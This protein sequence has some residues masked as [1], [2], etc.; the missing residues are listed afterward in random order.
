MVEIGDR[1]GRYAISVEQYR[2]IRVL[3]RRSLRDPQEERT[4]SRPYIGTH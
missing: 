4:A 1:V 2:R 3:L